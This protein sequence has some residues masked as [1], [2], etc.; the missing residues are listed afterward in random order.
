MNDDDTA[1]FVLGDNVELVDS[2]TLDGTNNFFFLWALLTCC[3]MDW[4]EIS[5]GENN[6]MAAMGWRMD[7]LGLR[8]KNSTAFVTCV[9]MVTV[10]SQNEAMMT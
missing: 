5:S 4:L 1:G 10:G 2:D 9:S 3:W 7:A 6:W 8:S